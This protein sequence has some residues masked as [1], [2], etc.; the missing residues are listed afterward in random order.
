MDPVQT[1]F[2]ARAEKYDR[3]SVWCTDPV[4]AQRTVE[5]VAAD[6]SHRVLDVACGTGLVAKNFKGK[7]AEL[8]GM[9]LTPAMFAQAEPHVDRLVAGDAARMPIS[10]AEFDRVVCRQ[11]IQFMDDRA[12]L[13]EM[14]RVTKPGGR[15]VLIHL[16]AYGE[17]D[18]EE[19]FEVLRL[20]N[21]ARRNF[22]VREDFRRLLTN[23]GCSSVELH[24]YTSDEDVGAWADNGAIED[25]RQ[26][27]L[28]AVYQ[29]ASPEFSALHAV[30]SEGGRVMD[31]MLFCIAIGVV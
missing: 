31:R 8:V 18:R 28:M 13:A 19:Y 21:P 2:H 7:V 11:G 12:V 27:E 3:S 5:A 30:R 25:E 4:L 20:R 29:K 1:H 24:D 10:N 23:A 16:V 22:Y 26:A 17:A 9:D 15:I 14:V 6:P